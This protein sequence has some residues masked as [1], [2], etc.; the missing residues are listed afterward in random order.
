MLEINQ[1]NIEFYWS[2]LMDGIA[3]IPSENFK[4][5]TIITVSA[6]YQSDLEQLTDALGL[7]KQKI[8]VEVRCEYLT[9]ELEVSYQ[10]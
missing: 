8:A 10:S 5:L 2:T 4:K 9:L 3:L 7:L 6:F 1:S